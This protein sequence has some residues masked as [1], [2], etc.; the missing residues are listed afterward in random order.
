MRCHDKASSPQSFRAVHGIIRT[1]SSVFD[2]NDR[3][4]KIERQSG[5]SQWPNMAG[6]L[7]HISRNTYQQ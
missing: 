3:Q 2:A 6:L 1:S 5:T 7:L 4:R